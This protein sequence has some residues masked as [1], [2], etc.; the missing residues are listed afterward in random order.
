MKLR[1]YQTEAHERTMHELHQYRSSLVVMATGLGKTVL[2]GHVAHDWPRGR[3][4]IM[5]HRDELIRQA[6][7]KIKAITGEPPAIEMGESTSDEQGWT[8]KARVVVTSVQTMSRENRL[9]RF[10]PEEFGLLICDEAH[11][12]VGRSYRTVFDHYQQNPDLRLLGVTATPKR[13][14]DLAMGQVF[15][16]VA[17]EYG[18]ERG[19]ADGW[20][21]P[22]QQ[23]AI[24][25]EGLDFSQVKSLAG[26]LHESQLESILIEEKLLHSVAAPTVELSGDRPTL[27]FCVTV[28]H[29]E[30][31]AE[32]IN[33]YKPQSALYL[34]GDRS[35]HSIE[36]RREQIERFRA[37][38]LQYLCNVGIFLEG[39]DA[40]STAVI[41]MARPTKS[42]PLYTQVIGRGT[43]PLPGI[44]DSLETGQERRQAIQDSSKPYMIVLDF[45]GNSGRHKIISAIDVLGGRY[46]EAVRE[47]ARKTAEKEGRQMDIDAALQRAMD[48]LALEEEERSRRQV[49]RAHADYRA[50]QVDVFDSASQ[51]PVV[52]VGIEKYRVTDKQVGLLVKLGVAENKAK[53]FS[54]RQA[55]TVIDKLLKGKRGSAATA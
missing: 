17:Y 31:M 47:Y 23:K 39:F 2:F 45:V 35:L 42:L 41:C 49:I 32:V 20:L 10:N 19:I 44:V 53:T 7:D 29:A 18:I 40:P 3:I 30:K 12:A 14:D 51:V 16:S 8:G 37:G 9:K 28:K 50:S 24:T 26:D 46:G 11:H 4:L 43:R 34:C 54:R 1:P 36:Y 52:G 22:I 15:E 33:R 21:V 25:V 5:A 27:V 6:A 55:S 38:S 13:A 48:E